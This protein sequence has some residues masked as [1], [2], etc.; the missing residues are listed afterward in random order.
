MGNKKKKQSW[1]ERIKKRN[2][3][4]FS[5][6]ELIV[7][8]AMM[9][10]LAAVLTPSLLA[11][12]ERSRAQKDLSAMDEVV[13]AVFLAMADP[14]VYDELAQASI[15][16]NVSCYIDTND[17]DDHRP[18]HYLETKESIGSNKALYTFSDNAR[19]QDEV[20]YYAAGNM[21]GT[22]ITFKPNVSSNKSKYVFGEAVI[23]RFF[24]DEAESINN[25]PRLYNAIRSVI[26][27]TIGL[28]SQIYRNSEYT[29]FIKIGT[30]GGGQANAQD[31]MQAYGQFSGTNLS[32]ED[33]EYYIANNRNVYEPE[34]GVEPEIEVN[35]L[36]TPVI[37]I[38]GGV[39]NITTVNNAT[40]YKVFNDNTLLVSTSSTSV[41]LSTHLTEAGVYTIKVQAV[42][43]SEYTASDYATIQYT[44]G[45]TSTTYKFGDIVDPGDDHDYYYM[46][47]NYDSCEEARLGLAKVM[48]YVYTGE[49]F[50]FE[51]EGG[52]SK[53][54]DFC[55][56]YT[57]WEELQEQEGITEE[58]FW[59]E[60]LRADQ[61]Y[62]FPSVNGWNVIA[63][64]RTKATYGEILSEVDGLPVMV[65]AYTFS[66]CENLETMPTIPSS[67]TTIGH[68]AFGWSGVS[69]ELIIPDSVTAIGDYA[70]ESC[71]NLTGELII[72][73]S[74]TI[75]GNYA[76]SYCWGFAGDLA[77]PSSVEMIGN[78]AFV[79]CYGFTGDLVIPNGV[80]SI[81]RGAFS[82]CSGFS[83]QLIISASVQAIGEGAF[84]EC[85]GLVSV[86]VD[87]TNLWCSDEGNCLVVLPTKTLI[88]GFSDSVIPNDGTVVAIGD[89][90]FYLCDD[91]TGTLMLPDSLER[92]GN[93]AF[94]G[95]R[96]LTG[97]LIIP[98]S[99]TII[100][101][102]AFSN[103]QNITN[104]VIGNGVKTIGERAFF[105]CFSAE[106]ITLGNGLETIGFGAFHSCKELRSIVIP[107]SVTFIGRSAF[108]ECDKLRS[109]KFA[110][111]NG[112]W[113]NEDETATNGEPLD[114]S[115]ELMSARLLTILRDY[116]HW[117][118]AEQVGTWVP[119]EPK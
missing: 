50:D 48:I 12:V 44:V 51:G 58:E 45:V 89:G 90:A 86:H 84:T 52:V 34:I 6:V 7:I 10:V 110:N 36:S 5:L 17:E 8:I 102:W 83:N 42:G 39:L 107:G 95:C 88:L 77:I 65:M 4:G 80:K 14:Y 53:L 85:S 59:N 63:K 55:W 100:E 60:I 81:G 87:D 73:E 32:L 75:I 82:L 27:D 69:G 31:A 41:D 113:C 9:A 16:E 117:S 108:L 68:E 56:G 23:N 99:V 40:G 119:G 33:R 15:K 111:P 118:C 24:P 101:D 11:Y 22:T 38:D 28:S 49:F 47:M 112:W 93:G 26:G 20:K 109:V 18:D 115:D 29:I 74:V 98:D 46:Y 43:G 92:I 72:P 61:L 64:D 25:L 116:C 13:N 103:C 97:N 106:S 21:R 76:F 94:N 1:A 19:Q 79:N 71:C 105:A 104:I 57:S 35:K 66:C 62:S 67:V 54:L 2:K 30:T 91:L 3:L 114:L 37:S 78:E 70:F 96:G